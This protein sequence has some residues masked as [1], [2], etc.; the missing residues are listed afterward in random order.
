MFGFQFD[1]TEVCNITNVNFNHDTLIGTCKLISTGNTNTYVMTWSIT[2]YPME[3]S[4]MPGSP[5]LI[6]VSWNICNKIGSKDHALNSVSG[7]LTYTTVNI[8]SF[9]DGNITFRAFTL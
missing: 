9:V 1:K 2:N 5:Y 8:P 6:K 4:G 7:Q 3:T